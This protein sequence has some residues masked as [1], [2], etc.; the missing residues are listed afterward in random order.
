MH[1]L[2]VVGAGPYG[3]SIAAH[4][5][6]AGFDL[7]LLGRPMASWRDHM[8]E[9]MFLKSEPWASDLSD[10]QGTGT[11]AAYAAAHGLR[12]E[13]GVPLPL[14]TFT[15]YGLWFAERLPVPVEERTVTWVAPHADGYRVA[16]AD[17]EVLL[18]R[19]VALAAGVL[20]L[21]HLPEPL[22]GLPR[23]LASHSS[24]HRELRRFRDK[25]VAVI[26]AGQAALETAALLAEAGARPTVLARGHDLRWNTP[27][28]P[29]RRGPL[30]TLRTP[31]SALGPGWTSWTWSR[32]PHAVRH[33]PA[34]ARARI[35]EQTLGPAGAWWLRERMEGRVP[36]RLG[37]RLVRARAVTGGVR[38]EF[39][40][41]SANGP[42]TGAAD[43][44]VVEAEHVIAA[45][46]FVTDLGR[47]TFLDPALR[48]TVR[49]VRGTA[50]PEL[51]ANIESS[52]PGL[53]FAGLLTAPSFGPAMRFVHGA[54]FT[55]SR[56]VRGVGRRL[57]GGWPRPRVPRP[58]AGGARGRA[59][60]AAAGRPG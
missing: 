48:Q 59:A 13:H 8:P 28:L 17:G 16:T 26:G 20:P 10:P 18:G 41:G 44:V 51:S 32:L 2:V 54:A 47:L 34:R 4:A 49:T 56:L 9:G 1:D 55:A 6:A 12:A 57:G 22:R 50:A 60:G 25:R 29:L 3:L 40:V 30:A 53:F 5:A 39:A 19:C 42:V 58:A 14:E 38:L 24:D 11:L 33:L 52:R 21:V 7:R 46:G 36:V 27:P 43:R 37:H 31:H 15:R 45:T 35:V 23:E